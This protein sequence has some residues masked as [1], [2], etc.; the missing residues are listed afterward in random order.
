M[1]SKWRPARGNEN[2]IKILGVHKGLCTAYLSPELRVSSYKFD[3]NRFTSC[4]PLYVILL[5]TW[6]I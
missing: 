1:D 6:D 3:G 2:K 5:Q 4:T